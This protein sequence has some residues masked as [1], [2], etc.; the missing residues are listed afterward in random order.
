MANEYVMLLI[1][2]VI[3]SLKQILGDLMLFGG[4]I[5]WQASK[6]LAVIITAI[7]PTSYAALH[8][9]VSFKLSSR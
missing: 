2:E 4:Y 6:L 8:E 3:G 7:E 5:G 1:P 9:T